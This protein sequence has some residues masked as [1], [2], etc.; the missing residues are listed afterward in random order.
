MMYDLAIIG[1]G[2]AGYSAA[3][4]ARR[5]HMSVVIFE[6][7]LLG[8]T[9]LNRGCV[10]TKYLSHIARKY[11][12][13]KNA[14]KD[15]FVVPK[16]GIDYKKTSS[17]MADVVASLR[18]GLEGQLHGDGVLVVRGDASIIGKGTISC[19]GTVY[20]AEYILIATGSVPEEPLIEGAVSSDGL[21]AIDHI[22]K[23]LH[24][25]G[26]G[27][28][29]VEFAEI[30]RMFG[31]K[32]TVSIRS[33]RIL[34]K[35][36]RE[37]SV[38]LAQSMRRKGITI[39]KNCDFDRLEIDREAVV[40]SAAGRKALL[41][42]ATRG[43]FDIG[44]AGGILVDE[45]GQTRTVGIYAAGDVVNGSV[46]L[47]HIGMEQGRNVVRH[48]VGIGHRNREAAVKCIYPAQE[49]ASVGITEADAKD[50]GIEAV[51]AKQTMFANARTLISTEERGFIK[52][53]VDRR[54]R[55]VL[56]A[57]LMCER[58]GDIVAEFALAIDQGLT[59]DEMLCSVRP[60]PSYCEAIS[61]VLRITEDK[62]DAR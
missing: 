47:A 5:H 1:G 40:L 26:G 24:V 18:N 6:R 16:I 20:E 28:A 8:G 17:R 4:E 44:L 54:K 25:L 15:G 33:E 12:E 57:Q 36:D 61:D 41:P 34:R 58:A 60:H 35:W 48:I 27:T 31:S 45:N 32:V 9:C 43:L 30:F 2:P 11:Y 10:P 62:L 39:Q 46:R 29:A 7:D 3:L 13:I 55:T 50:R 56:G 19:G 37:I 23:A 42:T 49:I 53:V 38:G 22:P 21:L 59:V 51:T 52:V 14:A